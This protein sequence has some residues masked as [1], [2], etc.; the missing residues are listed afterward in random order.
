MTGDVV[1]VE[2]ESA[3]SEAKEVAG[4]KSKDKN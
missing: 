2:K 4:E 3:E 1:S